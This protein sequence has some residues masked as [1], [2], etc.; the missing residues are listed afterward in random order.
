[1]RLGV[2]SSLLWFSTLFVA[3]IAALWRWLRTRRILPWPSVLL[4]LL[5]IS[6]S[7]V[8]TQ[9]ALHAARA[10]PVSA[11]IDVIPF[12]SLF[13][14]ALHY[15]LVVWLILGDILPSAFQLSAVWSVLFLYSS[16]LYFSNFL[17]IEQ[18]TSYPILYALTLSLLL[19]PHF[20]ADRTTDLLCPVFWSLFIFLLLAGTATTLSAAPGESLGHYLQITCFA[21][22]P[23]LLWQYLALERIWRA[24]A[25][26][27][28]ILGGL[29]FAFLAS[30]KFCILV[31]DLGLLPALRYRLSIA[32]V[33]PNWISRTLVTLFPLAICLWLTA[34]GLCSKLLWGSGVVA[35]FLT[36]AYTQSSSGF[37]GWLA[38]GMGGGT[39]LLLLSWPFIREWWRRHKRTRSLTLVVATGCLVIVMLFGG[40]LAAQMNPYSFNGRLRIWRIALYQ[41][42]H[43]PFWGDGVGVRHIATQY[44]VH[45]T[46]ASIGP[47]PQLLLDSPLSQQARQKRQVVIHTH[48]LFLEL[49]VGAGLPTLLAFVCFL[50]QMAK[51]GLTGLHHATGHHRTLIAGC[52]AGIVGTLG[53]GFIDVMEFSPPFFTFPTWV[54]VGLLLAAPRALGV[55]V[56]RTQYTS[57]PIL[58]RL[59]R[60]WHLPAWIHNR[61]FLLAVFTIALSLLILVAIVMPL[62]GNL[63]YRVAYSAYQ[64]HDWVTAADEL[65]Q[66]ARWEPLNAKYQ[67][68]R[69]EALINLGQ[70]DQAISAY[71]QAVRL[72]RD[73]AP[74]YAQLGW[75]YWLQG[76]LERAIVHF[77]KA[78]EM[79][80]RE[81]WRDGL[82]A[83]LALAYVAQGRVEAAIPLFKKT[84]EL[85]P[86]MALAP[87][88]IPIQGADGRFDIVLDP[89]YISQ[90]R[91]AL[92][93]RI[94]AHLGKANYT[95]RQFSMDMNTSSLVSFNQILDAVEADYAA[96]RVAGS[97]EAP[98]LLATVA[99]AA[100]L[101][102]LPH[103]AEQAYLAFQQAFPQSAYGFRD[104][105][106]LYHE[107]GRLKEA[108]TMLEQ[109][110]QVSPKDTASWFALAEVYLDQ[111]LW[112]QAKEALD[113]LYRLDPLNAHLYT[114]RARL[115]QNQGNLVGAA[116]ALGKSLFIQKSVPR[117][118]TLAGLYRQLG[119]PQKALEQ[120][121]QAADALF[122]AWPRPLD[123]QLWDIAACL[124]QSE[125]DKLPAEISRLPREHP[126]SGNVL[127]GHI[128]RARG[129]L[130]GALTAYQAAAEARPNEGAPHYFLGENYQAL[131]ELDQAA[132]EYLLAAQLD[133]LES[134]PMLAL[135]RMQWQQGDRESALASF[136]QAVEMTPGWGEA[137]TA[138]GNA[139]LAIGD[140]AGAAAHFE[141]AL[142]VDRGIVEGLHSD[143]IG[144]LASATIRAT[145]PDYVR[146]D[147]FTIQGERE[148]ERVL[149]MHP[150]SQVQY[151]VEIPEGATLAFRIAMAPDSWT[152]AGDGVTFNIYVESGR[153]KQQ[154]FS[155]YIDPKQNPADQRWYSHRVDLS[156]YAGQT[157]TLTL[158]TDAGP[159]GDIRYDWAGWG[160]PRLLVP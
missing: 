19:A 96:A 112:E 26:W 65:V 147:Y 33:G 153:E 106:S 87:Y 40:W 104:L 55:S 108:Q 101:A 77:E 17:A 67:Q 36:I 120:C 74:Y 126:L 118:L 13:Y 123:P 53:W 134:L 127:W 46:N 31:G 41:V 119:R 132:V 110:V 61:T 51:Y 140:S 86:Q 48:S 58:G 145:G 10:L 149:F 8:L 14:L 72:K 157:I 56:N 32:N 143:L 144:Q 69:G 98:A 107:Q 54:L 159:A 44:S 66:T 160:S 116:D 130:E 105:G 124:A 42:V 1:M 117:R 93:T 34:S 99:E 7:V 49:A 79:D 152:Q 16:Y 50:W 129:E 75:L 111:G 60:S 57:L 6:G 73:L 70:Y 2:M 4:V 102:G 81:A 151:T 114:L 109:A 25:A 52:I 64:K 62:L 21:L 30:V 22:L 139:L 39:L 90:S 137:H 94:L 37:S 12:L 155:Q 154:L 121:T 113:T 83:D 158:E 23:F 148:R 84:I 43:H 141:Q 20:A 68:L 146:N 88:W 15:T 125:G 89:V 35:M 71:E 135:G 78:V 97:R 82:H 150:D 136:S 9:H 28:V 131:G 91:A 115:A 133:P 63:H 103:R 27:V 11:P 5:Y 122:R 29:V 142:L 3:F 138:L 45:E 92:Q 47:Q 85:D 38:L 128:Y 18:G 24:A 80:P 100:R 59:H 95:P 156:D 76:D